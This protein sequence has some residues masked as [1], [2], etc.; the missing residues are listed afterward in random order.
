LLLK[1]STSEITLHAK[2]LKVYDV[3]AT[4]KKFELKVNGTNIKY[5]EAAETVTF[6]FPRIIAKGRVKLALKFKGVLND[7]MRGFYRSSHFYRGEEKRLATTQFEATDAR[8]AFPCFDEPAQKAV[9]EVTMVIPKSMTAISNTVETGVKEDESGFQPTPKM[10]TYLLAFIVGDFEH[11]QGRTKRGVQ[12][13]VFVTPGKKHQAKFALSC[14]IKVLD[15]YEKYFA[16]DYPLPV[17]DLIAI[18]DFA[19]GAMENWGAVTYRESALLIDPENSSTA[20][21]QWV[22][23]VIAHELSHQWFGD[24]VT[25]EWWTHLWLNEGFASYME[26]LAVAHLFPQWDIWTQFACNDLAVALS[27]DSLANTH[28]IEAE[29]NSPDEIGE[30]FD[31]VSYSKGASV[32][33]MLASFLGEKNFRDG[34]RYYLK[35]H[36]YRN[37]STTD[38]WQALE[39]ISKKPVRKMMQN[40][41]IK[42]GYPVVRIIE[43]D[44]KLT[45]KQT[46]FF[47]SPI[48]KKHS[49]DNT[50][51]NVPIR[52][53]DARRKI[54]DTFLT[55]KSLTI[56]KPRGEWIKFNSDETGF[57]RVDYPAPMLQALEEPIRTKKLSATV[58]R[59]NV[60]RDALALAEAGELPT[61][62]LLR[63]MQAYEN[64]TDYTVWVE[65]ATAL[66]K[67][68]NL[69]LS[70]EYYPKFEEYCRKLFRKAGRRLG[71]QA[72]P[73]EGHAQTLLRSLILGQ[74]IL[75]DDEK[76]LDYGVKL[77]KRSKSIP[78]DLR[79]VVYRAVAQRGD[80]LDHKMFVERYKNE[81]F[82]EEKDRL[83]RAL[84]QFKQEKILKKTLEFSMSDNVRAQD[85]AGIFYSCWSN[86]KGTVLAWKFTKENWATLS[87]RYSASG[88]MLE[89]FVVPAAG[90]VT[91]K[92]AKDVASFFKKHPIPGAKRSI[93]QVLEKIYSNDAW[94]KRDGKHI[95]RWLADHS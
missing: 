25:M 90:F 44:N 72:K 11:I 69:I 33:R 82:S 38:L 59:L 64:E 75:F 63:L 40:W 14:A 81:Q 68:R 49:K 91:V 94:F 30:I 17:L 37:A 85:T 71:W 24:L 28:P 13:R 26:Y 7:K 1:R 55:Q 62:Q 12:V 18:P 45:L 5:N 58:D 8:R 86:K 65:L 73:D 70:Q 6:I 32:I 56:K 80:E 88:H 78:S 87:A 74:L 57:Y 3:K 67:L 31:T 22:A 27:L 35:K 66:N 79:S 21:R 54:Q 43:G 77:F 83:G 84:G 2:E 20:S 41:T 48:S 52:T 19:A 36:S 51:W 60:L 53:Q 89:H 46:R 50:I 16:I 34:L 29:V 93:Q 92:D 47:S 9:F 61:V 95:E 15:F 10:S 39:K 76:T 42:A 23:V 4:A